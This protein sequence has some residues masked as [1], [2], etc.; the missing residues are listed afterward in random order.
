[1]TTVREPNTVIVRATPDTEPVV[2]DKP[3]SVYAYWIT[4]ELMRETEEG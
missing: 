1:M 3:R 4:P 2:F